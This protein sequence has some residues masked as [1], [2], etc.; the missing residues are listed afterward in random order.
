M[1][2]LAAGAAALTFGFLYATDGVAHGARSSHDG[3]SVAHVRVAVDPARPTRL[4]AVSF[5]ISPASAR[6]HIRV[7]RGRWTSCANDRG[8]VTCRLHGATIADADALQV[9]AAH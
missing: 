2:L 6:V 4:D 9:V 3:F 8:L 7:G 1:R 5:R